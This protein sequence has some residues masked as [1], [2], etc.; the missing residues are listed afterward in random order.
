VNLTDLILRPISGRDELELFSELPY[1][2]NDE[3]A[4]DLEAGRRRPE[5][6]WVAQQ[7][8]RLLARAAWWSRGDTET[9][10]RLDIFDLDDSATDV[11]L[12]D[13]GVQLLRTA[14]ANLA[15]PGPPDYSRFVPSDWRESAS[16]RRVVEDRMAV[17]ERMGAR[18]FVERLRL[19]WEPHG[20]APEPGH[21]LVF[22]QLDDKEEF[23]GLLASALDGSLDAH[24]RADLTQMSAHE[25]AV[26][27]YEEEFALYTSPR[28][29][30][31]TATLPDGEPV[32]FVI[33]A[34]NP[35]HSIIA[36]IAVLPAHRGKGYVDEILAEGTRV[37]AEQG[38]PRIRAST[39]L[40]NTPM[41][42]AFRRGGYVNFEREIVMTWG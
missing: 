39:D 13:V 34:A 19:E 33:P 26:K 30:W 41:A 15:L 38:V 22:R 36:Y 17:V 5:W 7:G 9:P 18:L 29:W 32:G 2:L 37:L 4:A 10:F 25:A 8:D 14:M 35:Y 24:D 20:A 12:V 6:M 16:T 28:E 11:D 42:N 1:A 31:R 23:V 3:F 40:G 27:H 21:R